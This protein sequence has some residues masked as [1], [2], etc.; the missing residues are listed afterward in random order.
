MVTVGNQPQHGMEA[1]MKVT[2]TFKT[3][4]A[5]FSGD[6]EWGAEIKR[7]LRGV[8]QQIADL[9]HVQQERNILDINGNAVGEVKVTK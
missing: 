9:P 2:I 7:I 4:N 6:Y 5:A 3:D 1:D 8:G